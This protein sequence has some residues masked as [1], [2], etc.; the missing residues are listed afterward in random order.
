V[1]LTLKRQ[2]RRM[3]TRFQVIEVSGGYAVKDARDGSIWT[4]TYVRLGCAIRKAAQLQEAH[5]SRRY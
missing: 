3:T 2:D 1:L 5:G 4:K